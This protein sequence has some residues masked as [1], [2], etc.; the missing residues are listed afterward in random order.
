MRNALVHKPNS[1]FTQLKKMWLAHNCPHICPKSMQLQ[2][3][4]MGILKPI[5]G[6]TL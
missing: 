6:D 1:T 4:T 3:S 2:G 5:R